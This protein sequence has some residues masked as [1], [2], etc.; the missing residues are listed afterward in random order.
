MLSFNAQMKEHFFH[1]EKT[2]VQKSN[3][4]NSATFQIIKFSLQ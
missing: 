4:L 1:N 2:K 3:E